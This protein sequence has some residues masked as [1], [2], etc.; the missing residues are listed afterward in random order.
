VLVFAALLSLT[1][2]V[3]GTVVISPAQPVCMVGQ[4]CSKP[5]AN[6]VLAFWRNGRRVASTR[7]DDAGN[8]RVALAPGRYAVTAP[9][10]HGIGRGLEPRQVT[11]PASRYARVNFTLDIGIR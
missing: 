8:Y 2:G 4:S 9:R 3:H 11:V 1:S 10:H 6:D 7:T 5:D